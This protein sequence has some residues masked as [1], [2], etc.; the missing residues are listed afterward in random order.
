MKVCA[1]WYNFLLKNYI[2]L[3]LMRIRLLQT[4]TTIKNIVFNLVL[5]YLTHGNHI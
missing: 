4:G 5:Q 2:I 1:K 3:Y